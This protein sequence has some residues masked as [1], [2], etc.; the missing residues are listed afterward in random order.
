MA[1]TSTSEIDPFKIMAQQANEALHGGVDNRAGLVLRALLEGMVIMDDK[2][3]VVSP[4]E[5]V[6]HDPEAAAAAFALASEI[7]GLG[8]SDKLAK[9]LLPPELPLMA[10]NPPTAS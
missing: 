8:L 9:G 1:G 2:C 10:P 7:A 3:E 6:R 4:D 5:I